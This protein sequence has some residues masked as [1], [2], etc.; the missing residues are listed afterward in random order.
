ME[1]FKR[2]LSINYYLLQTYKRLNNPVSTTEVTEERTNANGVV[3]NI[4]VVESE[5]STET[6]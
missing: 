3:K 1:Y 2:K 5:N 6:P 4:D